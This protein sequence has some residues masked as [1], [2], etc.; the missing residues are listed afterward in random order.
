MKDSGEAAIRLHSG[1]HVVGLSPYALGLAKRVFDIA[2]SFLA[3]ALLAPVFVIIAIAISLETR[4]GVLFVQTRTGRDGNH[5]A[6]LKFRSMH[7]VSNSQRFVQARRGDARITK[8]GGFLR[9]TSLDELPQLVNVLRG[10]MSLIGPRPHPP[11]LDAQYA[12]LIAGYWERYA[13]RPGLTGLAQVRGARGETPNVEAM[14]RRVIYDLEYVRG[15]SLRRDFDLLVATVAEV[16]KS[17][18]AF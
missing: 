1:D 2:A 12:P 16:V 3:L 10:D 8:V 11:D 4:G 13:A 6:M 15:A 7:A 5:F 18:V 14:S 9:R 17:D